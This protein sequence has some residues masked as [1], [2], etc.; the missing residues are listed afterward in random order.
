[1][2]SPA[3][4][5]ILDTKRTISGK[6]HVL[7]QRHDGFRFYLDEAFLFALVNAGS[8]NLI[9]ELTQLGATQEE[10]PMIIQVLKDTNLINP[11]NKGHENE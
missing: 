8:D 3:T 9:T 1:M 2:N 6:E 7:I 11:W 5:Q 4:Y 10:I